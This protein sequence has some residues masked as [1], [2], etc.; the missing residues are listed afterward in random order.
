MWRI[1][2]Q[3]TMDIDGSTLL[4]RFDRCRVSIRTGRRNTLP[5]TFYGFRAKRYFP[6]LFPG[7]E[8]IT[9]WKIANNK[10]ISQRLAIFT[11]S[12][13]TSMPSIFG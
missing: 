3:R 8:T 9:Q 13:D 6:L 11:M 7:F 5:E 4:Q 2:D 10:T 12:I 1:A